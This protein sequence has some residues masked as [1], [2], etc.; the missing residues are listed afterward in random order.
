M[1]RSHGSWIEPPDFM[2]LNTDLIEDVQIKT[3]AVDAASPLGTGGYDDR[4]AVWHQPAS[5]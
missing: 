1:A 3:A 5:R 2:L 4:D